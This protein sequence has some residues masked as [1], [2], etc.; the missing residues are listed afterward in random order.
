MKRALPLVL[1]TLLL[2]L[3]ACSST[4][5]SQSESTPTTSAA[6]DAT[7]KGADAED[8]TASAETL[9]ATSKSATK[10][11]TITEDNDPNGLIGRPNGYVSAAV[12]YDSELSCDMASTDC[13]VTVEVF[14]DEERAKARGEYLQ[15]IFQ[16]SPALGSEW[17]Y[18]KGPILV[19][20]SGE[21]KPSSA[22]KYADAFG[23][24]AVLAQD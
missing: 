16:E 5:P 11:V 8:A 21:L 14:P 6:A 13:G 12:I 7:S 4:E 19:R 2:T 10:V 24:D 3:T 1:A 22:K 9:K 15:K 23:G 20:V 18:V 17:D